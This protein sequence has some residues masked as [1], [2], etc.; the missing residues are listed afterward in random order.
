M[1]VRYT[2]GTSQEGILLARGENRMRVALRNSDDVA[3]F[4]EVN[5]IWVSEDCE[6][7]QIEFAWQKKSKQAVVREADCIC[8]HELAARLIHLLLSGD[9]TEPCETVPLTLES[10]RQGASLV[11]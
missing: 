2:D 8:S 6:P 10:G 7:V 11:M 4:T 3:E 9:S 1:I 5:G